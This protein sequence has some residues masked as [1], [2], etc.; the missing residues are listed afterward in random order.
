[1]EELTRERFDALMG[2]TRNQMTRIV[3]TELAW[4]SECSEKVLCVIVRDETDQDY[5]CIVLARDSVGR[6]RAVDLSEW[7][8]TMAEAV[9]AVPKLLNTW[10][11]RDD[12]EYEQGD[13]PRSTMDFFTPRHARARLNPDFIQLIERE[14]MSPAR[15]IIE[16]LMFYFSLLNPHT[17]KHPIVGW[18]TEPAAIV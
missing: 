3:G 18:R 15:G 8:A 2:S 13:E 9:E 16:S 6:F 10:A 7:F 14:E 4:Y 17:A 5:A 1:M 11:S 12:Q